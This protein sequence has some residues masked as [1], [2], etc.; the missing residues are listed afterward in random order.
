MDATSADPRDL[1]AELARLRVELNQSEARFRD[2]IEHNADAIVVVGFHGVIRFLNGEAC[3][4]F[5]GDR[6][7]L[8]GSSFGFPVVA[9]ETTL[10][11]ILRNGK[12]R[13]V[14]MRVVE[15]Q[16]AGRA[17]WIASLRDITERTLGEQQARDLIRAET[18][19]SAAEQA[20]GKFRFLAESTALLS[21]S[22]DVT[23][24]L[25]QLAELC[26]REI[27]DWVV[28]YAIDEAEDLRRLEV[29]H[30]EP[31]KAGLARRLR[32]LPIDMS[33]ANP[34]VQLLR[35]R[36]PRL[37]ESVD[38]GA[39]LTLIPDPDHRNLVRG[40]GIHSWM[41]V[42]MIA[43]ERLLGAIALVCAHPDRSFGRNDLALAGDLA[44]RAALAVDNARLYAAARHANEAKTKLL[45]VISHDLRT[46]LNSIIGYG[47]LLQMGLPEPLSEATRER[48]DRMLAS[49]RHQL[50]LIDQLL[51]FARLDSMNE[52]L[53][54][55]QVDVRR[56]AR[57]AAILIEPVAWER[58]LS[59]DLVAPEDAVTVSTDSD[60]LRQVL[61]NLLGNAV[62]YTERGGIRLEIE[63]HADAVVL[64]VR[65]TGIGIA[66]EHLPHIFEPFWQADR[67]QRSRG[68]GT[69]LGLNVVK[70]VVDLLGGRVFVQSTPGQ[71]SCFTIRIPKLS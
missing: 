34:V 61:L 10:L 9:G 68:G 54:L 13:T 23:M 15:S 5:G 41:L 37:F 16:W 31:S 25:S 20:A 21:S 49:A 1:L 27:A 50:Y 53:L 6:A 59:L 35:A 52:D 60:K 11:D 65:D 58:G 18:A 71:G 29:A 24:I 67:S 45:A 33:E 4:L 12:Q 28:V 17:A 36:K 14:E 51:Q 48:I 47:Q 62:R 26:I 3:E 2:I 44:S 22:L 69:G 7:K 43:R 32:E 8:I 55:V 30:R 57:E 42:P 70:Q 46:P 56:I 66:P 63:D 38:D 39:L 64:C 19:R 40:L